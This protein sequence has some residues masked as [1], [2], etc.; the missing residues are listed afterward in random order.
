MKSVFFSSLAALA[1]ASAAS[2][3]GLDT[4]HCSEGGKVGDMS[5]FVHSDGTSGI[6]AIVACEDED[7]CDAP[8]ENYQLSE[9]KVKDVSP[10]GKTIKI[11]DTATGGADYTLTIDTNHKAPARGNEE[12]SKRNCVEGVLTAKVAIKPSAE[13]LKRLKDGAH[14]S[15]IVGF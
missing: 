15:C 12:C 6:N 2:A 9:G 11:V 7:N 1:L 10:D 3:G 5:T 4:V 13:M 8:F 14:M